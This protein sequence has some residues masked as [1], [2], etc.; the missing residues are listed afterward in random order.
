MC[1]EVFPKNTSIEVVDADLRRKTREIVKLENTLFQLRNQRDTLKQQ[2]ERL[3]QITDSILREKEEHFKN[4]CDKGTEHADDTVGSD[5]TESAPTA[6]KENANDPADC[7]PDRSPA[8]TKSLWKRL[9]KEIHP[10]RWLGLDRERGLAEEMT[11][12]AIRA[13]ET[14]DA[15]AM[16][17]LFEE[18][19]ESPLAIKGDSLSD[20]IK[21][22][23]K[24]ILYL[25]LRI[26]EMEKELADL[27]SSKL[28]STY[29]RIEE[30][31]LTAEEYIRQMMEA[32]T[33]DAEERNDER[34]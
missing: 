31:G 29:R 24:L 6:Q 19:E 5:A 15:E 22:A 9:L 12:R 23:D 33:N 17:S 11:R 13:F 8:K 25:R 21:R 7:L 3:R 30:S 20:Q 32:S 10:D 16:A 34:D 26:Q 27:R 18:Y 28:F 1:T 2:L 4:S 14:G